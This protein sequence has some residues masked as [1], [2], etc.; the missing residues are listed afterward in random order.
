MALWPVASYDNI[1]ADHIADGSLR[2]H[3]VSQADT[4]PRHP[5]KTALLVGNLAPEVRYNLAIM[6]CRRRFLGI[7]RP[8]SKIARLLASCS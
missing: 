4:R 2:A 6:R 1:S 3:K 8:L 7:R 5:G